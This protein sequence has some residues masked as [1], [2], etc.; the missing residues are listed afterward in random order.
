MIST[1]VSFLG[2]SAFRLIFGEVSAWFDKRQEHRHEIARLAQQ[3]D[4]EA[5]AHARSLESIRLQAEL[6]VQTIRVQGDADM[7]RLDAEAFRDT[8]AGLTRST[9][10]RWIDG[11]N[12]SVRVTLAYLCMSLFVAHYAKAGWILDVA[13]LELCGAVFGVYLADRQLFRRGK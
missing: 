3:A 10:F 5:L 6:G 4:F 9:G 2:G 7:A 1:V 8:A 11:A 13:A 12:A